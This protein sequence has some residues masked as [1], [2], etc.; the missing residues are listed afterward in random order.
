MEET[1]RERERGWDG[2]NIHWRGMEEQVGRETGGKAIPT[3]LVRRE[4]SETEGLIGRQ[5][6]T[7]W[8]PENLSGEDG[9]GWCVVCIL[10]HMVI[11]L[12][13]YCH[14]WNVVPWSLRWWELSPV[15]WSSLWCTCLESR[16]AS[17]PPVITCPSSR[18]S[19]CTL[20]DEAYCR[21]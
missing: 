6:H 2:K 7:D 17:S 19:P 21:Y 1:T 3:W 14:L 11:F 13:I 16:P 15:H 5:N 9:R 18:T 8:K 12:P 4:L 20:C 10:H